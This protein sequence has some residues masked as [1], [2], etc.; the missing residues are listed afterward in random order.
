MVADVILT[1]SLN[2]CLGWN[3][4]RG[5]QVSTH[6]TLN[7][8]L[9]AKTFSARMQAP[10]PCNPIFIPYLNRNFNLKKLSVNYRNMRQVNMHFVLITLQTF[11]VLGLQNSFHSVSLDWVHLLFVC[12]PLGS[13]SFRMSLWSDFFD[14]LNRYCLIHNLCVIFK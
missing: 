4:N 12:F 8:P 9:E 1:L 2:H 10:V 7:E 14:I 6:L 5:C 11:M 13:G 3:V